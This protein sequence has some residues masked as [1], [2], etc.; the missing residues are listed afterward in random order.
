M[1][2]G[3]ATGD[4]MVS[5]AIEF[6]A[7]ADPAGPSAATEDVVTLGGRRL[8]VGAAAAGGG[9]PPLS[10]SSPGGMPPSPP[11]NWPPYN[12]YIAPTPPP[13]GAH[14]V[15][16]ALMHTGIA[17]L[18]IVMIGNKGR[19]LDVAAPGTAEDG[20]HVSRGSAV[21]Y[22]PSLCSAVCRSLWALA[23][24]AITTSVQMMWT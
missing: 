23:A 3:W 9:T 16:F 4:A 17:A 19:P 24:R 20:G 1:V 10:S 15:A 5:W 14:S 13:P 8:D 18:L 7:F 11:Q 6:S 12:T 21:A 22:A 2:V